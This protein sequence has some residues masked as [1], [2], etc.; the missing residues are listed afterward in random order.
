MR[1]IFPLLSLLLIAVLAHADSYLFTLQQKVAACKAVL[2]ISLTE[3]TTVK[4][5]GS[6]EI[7]VCKAK[8]VE[9]L[10]GAPDKEVAFRF[11][12]YGDFSPE[13][14]PQIVKKDYIVFLHELA[15]PYRA[16]NEFWVFQGP[17]G[18]RPIAADYQEYKISADKK[19]ATETLSHSNFVAAIRAFAA[20][21]DAKNK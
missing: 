20:Q 12:A 10:K 2:R 3:A 19:I 5:N 17:A 21:P 4:G 7:A 16:T 13:K 15:P 8:V 1:A 6:G 11:N 9:V 14:L 18:L